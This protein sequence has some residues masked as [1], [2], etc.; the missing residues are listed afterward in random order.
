MAAADLDQELKALRAEVEAL[1]RQVRELKSA[2]GP[3]KIAGMKAKGEQRA[4]E[5]AAEIEKHPLG[6]AL[7]ALGIGFVLGR[8]LGR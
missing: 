2:P 7:I 8:L 5:L 4:K 3:G 6:S 1:T